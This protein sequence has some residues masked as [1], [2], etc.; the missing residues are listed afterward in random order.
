MSETFPEFMQRYLELLNLRA[1]MR[2]SYSEQ[3]Q[4]IKDQIAVLE[5]H[6]REFC[7]KQPDATFET[8][9][10]AGDQI[11]RFGKLGTLRLKTEKSQ[12]QITKDILFTV[13]KN[14]FVSQGQ[15]IEDG[16]KCAEHCWDNRPTETKEILTRT[17]GA[18]R[19]RK[20]DIEF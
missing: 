9:E 2:E 7:Q 10:F 1:R 13:L 5:P 8:P 17:F 12:K 3:D 4:R 16:E 18:P 19:K 14:Y 6:V 20:L 15:S 11:A